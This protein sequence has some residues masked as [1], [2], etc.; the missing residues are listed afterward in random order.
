V[1]E[2]IEIQSNESCFNTRHFEW[3][4]ELQLW[5][6]LNCTKHAPFIQSM[7]LLD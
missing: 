3:D 6:D 7:L 1:K 2:W 5:D 4:Q